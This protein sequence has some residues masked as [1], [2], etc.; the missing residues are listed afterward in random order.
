MG[1][2]SELRKL[3]GHAPIMAIAATGIIY[4]EVKGLLLEKK[5]IQVNGVLPAAVFSLENHRRMHSRE[6]SKRKRTLN[7]P[8][9]N[10]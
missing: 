9:L 4:D 2:I 7:L 6:K 3:V 10:F 8:T 5:L 1:Y